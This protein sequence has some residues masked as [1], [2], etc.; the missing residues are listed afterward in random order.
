NAQRLFVYPLQTVWFLALNTSRAAFHNAQ[1]RRAVN[2]AVDRDA[3][4][5]QGLFGGQ[6]MSPPTDH[7]IPD[8]FPGSARTRIYPQKPDVR[9]ARGLMEGRHIRAVFYYQ[10]EFPQWEAIVEKNL[11]KIGIDVQPRPF[12]ASVAI[13]KAQQLH[14]PFDLGFGY[15]SPDYPDPTD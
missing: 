14:E 9:E 4:A 11:K 5:S 13:A 3:L 6:R 10:E 15:W 12:A 1:V 2:Y 7:L 8:A